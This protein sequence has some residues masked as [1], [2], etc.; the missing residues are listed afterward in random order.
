MKTTKFQVDIE[1]PKCRLDI[2]LHRKLSE[3]SRSFIQKNIKAGNVKVNDKVEKTVHCWLKNNDKIEWRENI[4]IKTNIKVP[5]TIKNVTVLFESDEYIII[6]KPAKLLVHALPD[7]PNIPSLIDWLI[8]NYPQAKQ[9]GEN[10]LRPALVHRLDKEVSGL[11]VIPLT[12]DMHDYLKKEFKLRRVKKE[13]TALAYNNFE[14]VEGV[15]N[16]PISRSKNTGRMA[17]H[18][19][20]QGG[21]SALTKYEVI[22]NYTNF[23]L[24]KIQIKTGRTNQ[25]RVH[26]QALGHSL[27]GDTLYTTKNIVKPIDLGRVFLHANHLGF[28]LPSGE[29][30]NYDSD[31]PTVLQNFL[32]TLK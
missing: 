18:S 17:A 6:D 19:V 28:N 25:I 8:E 13:Y 16:L 10:P 29:K 32:T 15:I 4:L 5:K 23:T 27:V 11:M 3:K 21:K 14:D 1:E 30:V 26:F 12:Q 24:L 22:K 31:L 9:L 20:E 7:K 2:F